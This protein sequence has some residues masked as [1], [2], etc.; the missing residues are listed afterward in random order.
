MIVFKPLKEF[1]EGI[2]FDML[3]K[4]YKEVLSKMSEEKKTVWMEKWKQNDKDAF[5]NLN[6]IGKC[7]FVTC[8]NDKIVGFGS[9]DPRKEPEIGIIGDNVVLPEFRGNG[10]GKIQIQE[11][12]RIFKKK[13]PVKKVIVSTGDNE[14]SIPAQKQYLSCG[15]KKVKRFIENGDKQIGYEIN[16]AK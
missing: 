3:V 15:F 9:Y 11:I 8:D 13:W 10:Y 1:N 7:Y 12:L 14:F 4:S 5:N 2:I 6:T 16:F